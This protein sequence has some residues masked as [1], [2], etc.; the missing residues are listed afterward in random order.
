MKDD[1]ASDTKYPCIA[2]NQ[3]NHLKNIIVLDLMVE[4]IDINF[5]SCFN[6][7]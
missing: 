1:N 6:I 7:Q 5:D 3:N 4:S 2:D